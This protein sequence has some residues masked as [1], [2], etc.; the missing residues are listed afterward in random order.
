MSVWKPEYE[1]NR[2]EKDA[3]DPSRLERRNAAQREKNKTPERIAYMHNYYKTHPEKFP[4]RDPVKQAEFNRKRRERYATDATFRSEI[5]AK[6]KAF[7]DSNPKKKKAARLRLQYGMTLDQFAALMEAQGFG[8]AICGYSDT[9]DKKMFPAIDHCHRTNV[10][11][12][13]LCMNC[14]MGIGKF[15]DDPKRLRRAAKYLSR[16]SSSAASTPSTTSSKKPSEKTRS[17]FEG[18]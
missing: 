13:I 18:L 15:K 11:R 6:V 7:W 14:N 17:L 9:R 4:R 8:C 1:E 2:R 16:G 3:A 10:V 5:K 12:G